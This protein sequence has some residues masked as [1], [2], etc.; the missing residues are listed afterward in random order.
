MNPSVR[1]FLVR[2]YEQVI[3]HYQQVLQRQNIPDLERESIRMR[4]MLAEIEL[5]AA[6]GPTIVPADKRMSELAYDANKERAPTAISA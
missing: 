1:D 5:E 4:L 2:G 3:A 6:S